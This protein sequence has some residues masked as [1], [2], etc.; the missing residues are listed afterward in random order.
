MHIILKGGEPFY[1]RFRITKVNEYQTMVP[2]STVLYE[3]ERAFFH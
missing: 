1:T 2:L 3:V